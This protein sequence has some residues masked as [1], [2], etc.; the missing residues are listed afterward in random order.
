MNRLGIPQDRI[1]KRL[2]QVSETI[3]NHLAKMPALA[4]PPNIDLSRGFTFAQVAEKQP[5]ALAVRS[6]TVAKVDSMGLN[7]LS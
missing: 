1:V 3:R 6:L 2:K 5:L 4:N 7:L